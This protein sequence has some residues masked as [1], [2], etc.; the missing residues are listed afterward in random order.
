LILKI[1]LRLIDSIAYAFAFKSQIINPEEKQR[2][3]KQS[4]GNDEYFFY[5]RH[6][7]CFKLFVFQLFN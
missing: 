6:Y 4:T 3:Q 7:F 5:G 2:H 1:I